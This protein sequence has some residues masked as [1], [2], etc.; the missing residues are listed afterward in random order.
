MNT[1]ADVTSILLVDDN[2]ANLL[3][4]REILGGLGK[5]LVEARSGVE[6]LRNAVTQDFAVILLDVRMPDMDGFETAELLRQY[7]RTEHTPILFVTAVNTAPEDMKKGYRLGAIDYVSKPLI[8][9]ILSAKVQ[10]FVELHEHRQ[11]LRR[12]NETLEEQVKQRTAQLVQSE[13]RFRQ[14][15]ESVP[16]A[17]LLI[18]ERGMCHYANHNWTKISGQTWDDCRAAGWKA[19]FDPSQLSKVTNDP[20]EGASGEYQLASAAG[21]CTWVELKIGEFPQAHDVRQ[22]VYT[23]MDVNER[24]LAEQQRTMLEDRL[25]QSQKLEAVGT[26]AGGIAHDFNNVLA[27]VVS[28]AELAQSQL[29]AGEAPTSAIDN[30]RAAGMRGADIVRQLLLFCRPQPTGHQLLS[31][32]KLLNETLKLLRSSLPTTIQITVD[33]PEDCPMILGNETQFQQVIMNLGSNAWHAMRLRGGKLDFTVSVQALDSPDA[34]K[35]GLAAGT[36][37]K[38]AVRDQ[39]HGMDE[40]TLRRVFEPFFSTKPVGEGSGLGMSVV[41]GI[42]RGH[43]GAITVE[44]ELERGTCFHVYFPA[45]RQAARRQIEKVVER[46]IIRG[47]G[48][49]VFLIDDNTSVLSLRSRIL[50]GLGYVVFEYTQPEVALRDLVETRIECDVVVT[51]FAMPGM[52]GLKFSAALHYGR[53]ELPILLCTGYE[54]LVE[55]EKLSACGVQCVLPKPTTIEALSNALSDA[56][57]ASKAVKA[58]SGF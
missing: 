44:S 58:V 48:E 3:A 46:K 6:A 40:Y 2:P 55:R 28:G 26:L 22:F 9:E 13:Q 14:L 25:I 54:G 52:D 51:D 20:V 33:V 41:H 30:I 7:Q 5:K 37:V 39:G 23:F 43:E 29:V 1:A 10:A 19:I 17:I 34:T 24:K 12:M 49:H 8:P 38:L 16:V 45:Q 18:D 21:G 35:L 47:N 27:V 11:A 36:Y 57:S 53:P 4:L 15:S 31:L 42:L 32:G 50:Q 56:L